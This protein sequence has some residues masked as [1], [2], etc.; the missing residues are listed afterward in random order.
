M[1]LGARR[2]G[3]AVIPCGMAQWW[4]H[5]WQTIPPYRP[6]WTTCSLKGRWVGLPHM[7]T[8]ATN[9]LKCRWV[10]IPHR[11]TYATRSLKGRQVCM[12]GRATSSLK[13]R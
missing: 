13:G 8:W 12:P 10:G 6:T 2:L 1:K 3:G 11:P 9:S 4:R 7:S 5:C